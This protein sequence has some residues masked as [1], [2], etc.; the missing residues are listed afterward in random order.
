MNDI[1][2]GY[3]SDRDC[4][5]GSCCYGN[6]GPDNRNCT[7]GVLCMGLDWFCHHC[8]NK[9]TISGSHTVPILGFDSYQSGTCGSELLDMVGYV[10]HLCRSR[11]G[12][13]SKCCPALNYSNA[14]TER[15]SCGPE[16][17][18]QT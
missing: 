18:D 10:V 6:G 11:T 14:A 2:D 8:G 17:L 3:N 15:A 13:C 1:E 5:K 16:S 7:V 12:V 4:S 9:K